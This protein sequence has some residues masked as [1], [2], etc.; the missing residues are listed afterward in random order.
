MKI[1]YSY[2]PIIISIL[3]ITF[4]FWMIPFISNFILLVFLVEVASAATFYLTFI[5]LT[6]W[7]QSHSIDLESIFMCGLAKP[8]Y[9]SLDEIYLYNI[10]FME[11]ER[12]EH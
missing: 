9:I 10:P 2:M 12:G 4:C 1:K 11:V 3:L 6:L 7:S 8:P 5:V